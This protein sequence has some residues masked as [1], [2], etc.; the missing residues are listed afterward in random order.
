ML[1]KFVSQITILKTNK[2]VFFVFFVR[3]ENH[4]KHL[5]PP[6]HEKSIGSTETHLSG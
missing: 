5:K 3:T 6:V 1:S 4:R 2:T